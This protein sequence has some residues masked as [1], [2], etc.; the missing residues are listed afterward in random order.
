MRNVGNWLF[1]ISK[2]RNTDLYCNKTDVLRKYG[3]L[4]QLSDWDLQMARPVKLQLQILH[5][6]GI[7]NDIEKYAY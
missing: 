1:E 7:H 3:Q 5:Y 2:T 4:M 6:V